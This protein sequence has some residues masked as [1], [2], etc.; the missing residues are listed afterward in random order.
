MVAF[1]RPPARLTANDAKLTTERMRVFSGGLN[2]T[3]GSATAAFAYIDLTY[4]LQSSTAEFW[5][6]RY[7]YHA[8]WLRRRKRRGGRKNAVYQRISRKR[9]VRV[10]F[11]IDTCDRKPSVAMRQRCRYGCH[12]R[13][14]GVTC[15]S[16]PKTCVRGK[17]YGWLLTMRRPCNL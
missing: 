6:R 8:S 3:F 2:Y 13:A 16:G 1:N 10:L 5:Q 15:G 7:E 11:H 12:R 14:R 4:N 9:P 17:P